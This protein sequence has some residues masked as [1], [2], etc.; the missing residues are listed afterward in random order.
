LR[1]Y[2]DELRGRPLFVA[3]APWD[4]ESVERVAR[5]LRWHA[6]PALYARY[7]VAIELPAGWAT[8][9]ST[10]RWIRIA[11][12]TL[13]VTMPPTAQKQGWSHLDARI[14]SAGRSV[15]EVRARLNACDP[16][17]N[18][19]RLLLKHE[20]DV[21]S[22]ESE[23]TRRV[24]TGVETAIATI[25]L[26]RACPVCRTIADVHAFDQANDLFRCHCSECDA[27]W[28]RRSCSACGHPFPILDFPGN[29]PSDDLLEA[30]RRYG[31]DVLALP[32]AEQAYL[33]PRCGDRSDAHAP[34]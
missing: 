22:A 33:C 27:T 12:R 17:D 19:K 28:G 20:L 30:D 16:R 10:P 1:S 5:M 3:V 29:E 14:T 25:N 18:R 13:Y 23:A 6:W 34:E 9:A 4:L 26:L 24:E 7:P 31:A 11:D 21:T 8:P 32:V 2:S 15:D